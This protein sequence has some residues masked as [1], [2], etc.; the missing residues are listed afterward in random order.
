[1]VTVIIYEDSRY[2]AFIVICEIHHKEGIINILKLPLLFSES[3]HNSCTLQ[4]VTLTVLYWRVIERA[5]I[6]RRGHT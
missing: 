3:T 1:M 6:S 5:L 4:V 2:E